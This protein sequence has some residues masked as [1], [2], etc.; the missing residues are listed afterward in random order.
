MCTGMEMLA[1]G[2]LAAGG[3]GAGLQAGSERRKQQAATDQALAE[4]DRQKRFKDQRWGSFRD[5]LGTMDREQ[6]D[7]QIEDRTG[8]RQDFVQQVAQGG[9]RSA[10]SDYVNPA[11][12][13]GR[14]VRDATDSEVGRNLSFADMLGQRQAALG[15]FGEAMAGGGRER[16]NNYFDSNIAGMNAERSRNIGAMEADEAFRNTGNRQA[17][18]GNILSTGG[19]IGSFA[20]GQGGGW[21]DL[22]RRAF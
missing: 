10:E 20:A 7:Q 2:S 4:L 11:S 5:A 12:T 1:L 9:Q 19:Q 14:V 15:G 6:V 13:V 8:E 3:A 21:G 22:F 17:L 16:R 18:I